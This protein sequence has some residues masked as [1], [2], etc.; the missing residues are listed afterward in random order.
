MPG[1]HCIVYNVHHGAPFH[2]TKP[3]HIQLWLDAIKT[4]IK[5]LLEYLYRFDR[6]LN[7][8][9]YARNGVTYADQSNTQAMA[10]S[11]CK[12]S[13]G[14]LNLITSIKHPK[15]TSTKWAV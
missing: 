2:W 7:R 10:S 14:S 5:K 3:S 4:Q 1:T 6:D 13:I 9:M 12:R 15:S 11:R 8:Y